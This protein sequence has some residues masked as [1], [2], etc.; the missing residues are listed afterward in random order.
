MDPITLGIAALV[1]AGAAAVLGSLWH[2]V[3]HAVSEYV[4]PFIRRH[5]SEAV[6]E[7]LLSMF[8]WLDGKVSQ[9]R[10]S[11]KQLW[12]VFRERVL[13]ITS[14]YRK[15]GAWTATVTTVTRVKV[16][17][18]EEEVVTAKR[19][20]PLSELPPKL[21]EAVLS[22]AGEPVTVDIGANLPRIAAQKA[23]GEGIRPDDLTLT[24]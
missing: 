16:S 19:D 10:A 22:E 1:A 13:G 24:N 23:E 8:D 5:V 7:A 15:T 21:R 3:M 14:T 20:V 17:A 2:Y 4:V 18:S 12:G 6:G 11:L 9:T